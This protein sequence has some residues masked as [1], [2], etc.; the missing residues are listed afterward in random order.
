M[1]TRRSPKLLSL[2]HITALLT[3]ATACVT[4]EG[5]DDDE[6]GDGDGDGACANLESCGVPSNECLMLC[7]D[8][9]CATCLADS[10]SCGEDCLQACA[11]VTDDGND[12]ADTTD[13][14][15]D[16]GVPETECVLNDEC[17]I[18][19]ECVAC[20]L[21]DNEGWCFQSMECSFDDDCGIDGKCGYNVE[22]SDYR[23][24]PAD[25]CP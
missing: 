8:D 2:L 13:D 23:C 25:H 22:T 5:G 1:Q 18:S 16:T 21:T 24:L 6:A 15:S 14:G 19:F 11:P 7:I 10:E 17:G 20:N 3:V 4:I 9:D 12:E